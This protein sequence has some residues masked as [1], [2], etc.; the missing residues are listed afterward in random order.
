MK[1][2][3]QPVLVAVACLVLTGCASAPVSM[4]PTS[5]QPPPP[6]LAVPPVPPTPAEPV[7]VLPPPPMPVGQVLPVT[8][9]PSP[10]PPPVAVDENAGRDLL[11][12]L[13]PPGIK[14]R[15]GWRNDILSAFSHLKIPQEATWFCAALAVIEQESSWQS[16]PVVPNL[17]QIV[18][19]EVGK[20]AG[21]YHVP[22]LAIKAALL[23][24]SPDGRSYKARIDAL[25]TETEMNALFEDMA[26]DARK[27]G[28]PFSMKNPIRTGGPM[29]VSV[30]FA[31]GHVRVWPYPY[32]YR[33]SI[34]SEVFS[35]RGG[36]YFGIADLLQYRVDYPEMIYRFADYNAGRYS[37]RNAAFQAAVVSL[38]R[39]KMPLDGDLLN[40]AT[41]GASAT[42]GQLL[43][44]SSHLGLDA[45]VIRR[46]LITEKN[47]AFARSEVYKRVFAAADAKAGHPLPRQVMPQI[48]LS[49]PKITRKLTTEWFAKR[50][51]GR[52]RTC[53][54][55]QPAR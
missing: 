27:L 30:E 50:V 12:R 22:L 11:Q 33:G 40:Y 34:R 45:A 10:V 25:K 43:K 54:A 8:P 39:K 5:R 35:R 41:G 47:E 3:V 53:L 13:L 52:Y 36:L 17:D 48:R 14:D 28:L 20:R 4:T 15:N 16:D 9:A 23:K 51:D 24:P 46:D 37:S 42:E 44:L 29:Q 32:T 55:R 7:P 26:A 31:E 19:R 1:P 21:K 49:S 38:T 18:W 6:I 2:N